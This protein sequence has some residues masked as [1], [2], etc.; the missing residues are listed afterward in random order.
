MHVIQQSNRLNQRQRRL[1][2]ILIGQN[3]SQVFIN[4]AQ[5][6][7]LEKCKDDELCTLQI[8]LE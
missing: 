7:L 6:Q 2:D 1:L 8:I 3:H 4:A 5:K